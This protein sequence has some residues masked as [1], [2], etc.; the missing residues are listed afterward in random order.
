MGRGDRGQTLYDFALGM[1]IFLLVLGYVFAFVPSLF[2]PFA[3]I[4]DSTAVRADRT[5]D[6][7]VRDK[8]LENESTN[9]SAAPSPGVLSV[10]CTLSFFAN[11]SEAPDYCR[12]ST[13]VSGP[14]G[15]REVAGLPERTDV[16]VTMRRNGTVQTHPDTGTRLAVGP[17]PNLD[18]RR[19]IRVVR[20]VQF[21]GRDY[22]FVVKLW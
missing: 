11:M 15:V 9:G 8:L 12:Y 3:P 2:E 19:V 14:D 13:T 1:A 22:L 5:A 7:L 18:S 21:D 20:V 6:T 17:P 16:N 4:E 10:S